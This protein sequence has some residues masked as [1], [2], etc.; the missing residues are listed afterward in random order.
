MN[1]YQLLKQNDSMVFLFVKNGILS[2][3]VIRDMEIFEEFNR[4][5]N[6]TNELKYILLG[7][8][9]ELSAKRIEQIITSMKNE[10]KK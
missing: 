9:F 3:Q 2:Y 5:Q 4:L 10:I 7:E 8:Q 1:R 6:L